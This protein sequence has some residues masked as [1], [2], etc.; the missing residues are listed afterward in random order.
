VEPPRE[1]VRPGA[2]A[3]GRDAGYATDFW[4][5]D[6]RRLDPSTLRVTAKVHLKL[7]FVIVTSMIRDDAFLPE[8]VAVGG[9]SV[10]VASDRGALARADLRLRRVSAMLRL[11]P[12][13]S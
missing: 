8:A 12:V 1:L 4:R 2:I 3:V 10:W 11:P 9:G 13:P 5:G 6:V 7:P